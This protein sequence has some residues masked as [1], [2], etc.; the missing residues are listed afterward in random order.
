[1]L[2]PSRWEQEALAFFQAADDWN[3]LVDAH[4]LEHFVD[5]RLGVE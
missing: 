5:L 1:M 3:A 4:S 2:A